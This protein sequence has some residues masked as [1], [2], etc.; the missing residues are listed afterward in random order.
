MRLSR[1]PPADSPNSE[2]GR[3]LPF[4]LEIVVSMTLMQAPPP[5]NG[6]CSVLTPAAA[7]SRRR[8]AA[9]ADA[10][11]SQS[12]RSG[13]YA[14]GD[15]REASGRDEGCRCQKMKESTPVRL[16]TH[17]KLSANG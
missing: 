7:G 9:E 13:E 16:R 2:D 12:D 14:G 3:M 11:R 17:V 15:R 10:G 4:I 6:A 1:A 8:C 5:T